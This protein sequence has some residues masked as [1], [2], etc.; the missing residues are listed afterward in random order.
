MVVTEQEKMKSFI[1][2]S[3]PL[4]LMLLLHPKV[5]VSQEDKE[6][7]HQISFLSG[8]SDYTTYEPIL[9][10]VRQSSTLF[11]NGLDYTL[12]SENRYELGA[13]LLLLS[14][15]DLT[16]RLSNTGFRAPNTGEMFGGS[17]ESFYRKLIKESFVEIYV[18][19]HLNGFYYDKSLDVIPFDDARAADLLLDL[20]PSISIVKN[21]GR[22]HLKADLGLPLIGYVAA[23]TR[24][25]E[26]FPF[27]LIE[28]EKNL[29]TAIRYGDIEFVNDYFNLNFNSAYS[30]HITNRLLIGIQYGFQYYDYKKEEPFK[31]QAVSYRFLLQA[32]YEF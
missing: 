14:E 11:T 3:I 4:W 8:Y 31:V 32:K 9:S 1:W 28:R 19:V 30:F 10:S 23:K 13:K 7:I 20:G 29:G 18:G 12:H 25:S 15:S 26:T 5:I 2:L 21:L 6:R 27:K 22:H 17:F 24:N 16:S